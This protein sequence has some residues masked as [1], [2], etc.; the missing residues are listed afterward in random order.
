M[1]YG[2]VDGPANGSLLHNDAPAMKS[3]TSMPITLTWENISYVIP[4]RK[5][6]FTLAKEPKTI[7]KNV[8]GSVR[9]GQLLAIIGSTGAGKSSLLDVLAQRKNPSYV[10]GRIRVNGRKPDKTFNR[11]S[12]YVTQDD[13]FQGLLTVRETLQFYADLQLPSSVSSRERQRRVEE[14]IDMLGLA[15]VRDARVGTQFARGISGGEKKRLSIGCSLIADPGIIF[16][17]EPTTGLDAYNSYSVLNA[18]NELCKR[19]R[20]I[21]CTI[22]QP[23]STIFDLFDQLMVLSQGG[24]AY[25]GPASEAVEYFSS[26]GFVCPQYI[27]PADYFIDVTVESEQLI[28]QETMGVEESSYLK[29]SVVETGSPVHLVKFF[30]ESETHRRAMQSIEDSKAEVANLPP[31]PKMKEFASSWIRQMWVLGKRIFKCLL[32]N[33]MLT[34]AQLFQTI[35]MSVLVGLL[36]FDIGLCQSSVQ[37]RV[38]AL[39]FI[40]TNQGFAMMASLNVFLEERGLFNRERASGCYRTSTYFFGKLLIELPI[41]L[42]Y[43]LLFASISYWMIGLQPYANCFFAFSL[44][45]VL[46]AAVASSLFMLLGAISPNITIAQVLCPIVLVIFMIFGGLFVNTGSIPV[47]FRWITYVS[48]F[49][50][51]YQALCYIEFN[52]FDRALQFSCD[53]TEDQ[54]C[55][56][57]NGDQELALLGFADTVVWEDLLIILS[58]AIGYRILAYFALRFF[59]KERR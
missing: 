44:T 21:V 32:R 18:L 4:M 58:M 46:F 54:T 15:K 7:L 11:L 53:C 10:S 27:N 2:S 5:S 33:P 41:L 50:W 14:L 38:G 39:F 57:K 28:Y 30:S 35:L 19:G 45:L 48:F 24:V 36:Y 42:F 20:T 56:V 1:D 52:G 17:D 40:M 43:P 51:G 12:S 55:A 37:N 59:Y 29:P 34:Y 47:Y 26:V 25:F 23:R 3:S 13:C 16:L 9:P 22:H 49:N 6:G 8:S 31:P